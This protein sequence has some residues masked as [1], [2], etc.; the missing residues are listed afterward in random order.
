MYAKC[1]FCGHANP[2]AAKYC[3]ECA[4]PLHLKPCNECDAINDRLASSCYKCGADIQV[5]EHPVGDPMPL[6]KSHAGADLPLLRTGEFAHGAQPSAIMARALPHRA[7]REASR[8]VADLVERFENERPFPV[9]SIAFLSPSRLVSNARVRDDPSSSQRRMLQVLVLIILIAG[10]ASMGYLAYRHPTAD[11]I[12]Q[13]GTRQETDRAL[14][15]TTAAMQSTARGKSSDTVDNA[16][17]DLTNEKAGSPATHG[18]IR[19]AA[20][21]ESQRDAPMEMAARADRGAD[22][23]AEG[24][25]GG[26]A[27]SQ[28]NAIRSPAPKARHEMAAVPPRNPEPHRD[29]ALVLRSGLPETP[30]QIGQRAASRDQHNAAEERR[31]IACTDPVAVLGLCKKTSDTEGK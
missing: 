8:F 21:S 3:N 24:A 23:P 20:K 7:R 28:L 19:A 25:P 22:K 9:M 26:L 6:V 14:R 12:N 15:S 27:D 16:I 18:K 30:A 5:A 31:Q 13:G 4:S 29:Q 17:S 1:D 11:G 10:V 2:R